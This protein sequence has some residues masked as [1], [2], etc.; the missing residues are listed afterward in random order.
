MSSVA[1]AATN[2]HL[3]SCL[4]VSKNRYELLSQSIDCFLFQSHPNKELIIVYEDDNQWMQEV[5]AS[6]RDD[7]IRFV[8]VP[9]HP[10]QTLGDLRNR[11]VQEASGA[12]I[13]QWDDDDMYHPD[14]I[15]LQLARATERTNNG[16]VGN[17]VNDVVI[18][19]QTCRRSFLFRNYQFDG[20]ML[21][22]R[23]TLLD[24]VAYPSLS[25]SEDTVV[26]NALLA[27]GSISTLTVPF[28]YLYRFHGRN[29]WDET[30]FKGLYS[31]SVQV[32]SAS[33]RLVAAANLLAN[34]G[35]LRAVLEAVAVGKTPD[36]SNTVAPILHQTWNT[37]HLPAHLAELSDGWKALHPGWTHKVWTDVECD[38]FVVSVWPELNDLYRSFP[39]PNQRFNMIR[40]LILHTYGGVFLDLDMM[41]VRTLDFLLGSSDFIV[42]KEPNEEAVIHQRDFII[43]NAFMASPPLHPFIRHLIH[44]MMTH[45]TPFSDENNVILD[46]TGPFCVSRVYNAMPDG[47]RVLHSSD[48]MSLSYKDV[49]ACVS[50]TD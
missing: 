50:A 39:Y 5:K 36:F 23:Q 45:K 44:D 28:L 9:T 3:V 10:K 19:D 25:R 7:R 35:Y 42:C 41:P 38:E 26:R 17:V 18:Y 6:Y 43:S 21:V 47:V 46:T 40:Y 27:S 12:Y 37:R 4:C 13:I 1:I 34:P 24:K 14:R 29:T 31:G 33:T 15:R 32:D 48:F 22:H 30:H 2:T 49:D 16:A 20:S 8:E 11:S